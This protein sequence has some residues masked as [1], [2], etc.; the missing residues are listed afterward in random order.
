[1]AA[2]YVLVFC[3]AWCNLVQLLGGP[4]SSTIPPVC[5]QSA[6][7]SFDSLAVTFRRIR[8][9]GHTRVRV[10]GACSDHVAIR[11]RTGERSEPD[12]VI[13]NH[14]KLPGPIGTTREGGNGGSSGVIGRGERNPEEHDSNRCRQAAAKRQLAEVLVERHDNAA[15]TLC[16]LQ[17]FGV[18]VT[19]SILVNPRD[20][21]SLLS[22]RGDHCARNVLVG[23]QPG[24]HVHRDR[25]GYTLSDCMTALAYFRQA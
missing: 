1:M 10:R 13:L 7:S 25:R 16:S 23:D 2:D 5:N 20:V 11:C 15:F 19:G 24:G 3:E 14:S 21:V 4:S 12:S 9:R 17:D 22:K 8:T 18:R 6:R